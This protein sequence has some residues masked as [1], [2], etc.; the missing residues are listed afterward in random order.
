MHQA[1]QPL[2]RIERQVKR[3]ELQR[4]A[5]LERRVLGVEHPGGPGPF[6]LFR[7]EA[8]QASRRDR[9]LVVIEGRVPAVD[10]PQAERPEPEPQ[11]EAFPPV[12]IEHFIEGPDLLEVLAADGGVVRVEVRRGQI[13]ESAADREWLVERPG[14][15]DRPPPDGASVRLVNRQVG[16]EK[17]RGREVIAVTKTKDGP[18]ASANA[19]FL[20]PRPPLPA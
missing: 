7:A 6:L 4:E 17:G 18:P 9:L 1:E 8:A 12:R 20:A 5:G 19:W 10:A 3:R 14:L 11:V 2:R 13:E 15:D 16:L